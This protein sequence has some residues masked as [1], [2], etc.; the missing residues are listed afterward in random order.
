[1]FDIR[2]R[3][4]TPAG[5]KGRILSTLSI[6]STDAESATATLQFST[7][8][9][10]AGRLEAPF[11]VGLE[12]TTGGK[13]WSRPRND[14]YVVL[15][16]AENAKDQ[17][18][19]M[20]F[21]A[22]SYVGWLLSQ[23][24]HWW[25]T[26]STDGR[27]R[28]Y[29]M[30]PGKLVKQLVSEAQ[31]AG[32]GWAPMLTTAFSDTADSLG[33][34]WKADDQ[35]KME[36]D[37]WRPYSTLFQSW[38]E[39]GHF[40]WWAEGTTLML[41]RL[42]TGADLS[43]KIAL[44]GPGFESAP[45]KTD[46]KGTFSTIVLIP[47]KASATHAFNAGADTRFGALE[48]SMTMSGVSDHATAV[49]MAQPVMREN[50]A[51]KLEL[52]F[53]WTPAAG[54]PVPWVDFTIGDLVAARR[55]VGK[56]PQRVVGIQVS[57]RD[58]LVSARA[59]VGSKLVGLQAKIAKRAGSASQGGIIGGSGA[60]IPSNPGVKRP[61]PIAPSGLLVT[62][63]AYFDATG[64][65]YASV[66]ATCSTVTTD[67]LGGT[68]KV[69]WYELWARKNS[70]G[71]SWTRLSTT[72]A[73]P[74]SMTYTGLLA[75]ESW[76]FRVRAYVEDRI[77]SAFSPVFSLVLAKDAIAPPLPAAPSGVSQRAQVLITHS[78]LTAA[79]DEQPVD[80][81]HFNV[82]TATTLTGTGSKVGE[83]RGDTFVAP[84]QPYNQAR[85]FWVTAQD[86]SGN[87]SEPSERI[88]VTTL[89]LVDTDMIGRII[90]DAN[91]KLG[92]IKAEL[93]ENG[94]ILQDKLADNAVSL[95]KLDSAT[96]DTLTNASDNATTANGRVTT[97]T[98][99]PTVAN[100]AGKPLGALWF[101]YSGN[102]TLLGTWRWNGAAWDVQAWG[103]DAIAAGAIVNSKLAD[104]SI[105]AVKIADNAIEAGKIAANAVTAREILAG[106]ITA[107]SGI[108]ANASVG[109]AQIA[110]AA[111]TNAKIGTLDAGKITSGF[112][113]VARLQANSILA[114][115]IGIGD[116]TNYASGSDFENPDLNPWGVVAGINYISG[117]TAYTGAYSFVLKGNGNA[118]SYLNT[119]IPAKPGDTF[120]VEF[121]M[122]RSSLWDGLPANSKLRFGSG[123][124][125]AA[126]SYAA[127][128]AP[129]NVWTKRSLMFT[130][131]TQTSTA[132]MVQMSAML[133]N[134]DSTAGDCYLD[135]IVIRKVF[136]G[137]LL[138]D[139][140]ITAR[141][142]A[143]NA[144]TADK[145]LARAITTTKIAANAVTANEIAA[146]TITA[147]EIASNAITAAKI[148]ALA[149]QAGH[150]AA[151]AITA[152]K[153]DAGAITTIKLAALAITSEKIAAN[154][155]TASEL[156][157]NA[158]T[159]KHTITG[160]RFRTSAVA[161]RGIDINSLGLTMFN[162]AGQPTVMMDATNGD[163]IFTGTI[164]NKISGPRVSISSGDAAA[165]IYFYGGAEGASILPAQISSDPNGQSLFLY[166][167]NPNI[168]TPIFT[169]LRLNE[170]TSPISWLLG[171]SGFD[172]AT[173]YPR[174][175]GDESTASYWERST[176]HRITLDPNGW[177]YVVG[178]GLS[179]AGGLSVSGAKSFAME[180]PTKPGVTL[181]HAS[182]ESPHNGVEYWSDGL[183]EMP[184]QGFKTVTL[185]AY[186]EALTAPDHR[187]AILTA[188]SPDAELRYDPIVNGKLIV[189]GTPGALF[190][191]VVKARRVQ[192]VD[193]QDVLAFP[194]ESRTVAAVA[195]T[196]PEQE[197]SITT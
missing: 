77:V 108:L 145:V 6:A 82:W 180:H 73:E 165:T 126:L 46:F 190:S 76:S 27:T 111:I 32:R 140:A 64:T 114:N 144:I 74:P 12:Y 14:L 174:I 192:I 103:Q 57:K 156:T 163:A 133:V 193:G 71:E 81:S 26:D 127:A 132:G 13:S 4:F 150:I 121:W 175:R 75:G 37:L 42:G 188:G 67:V 135:D 184:A 151:N 56:L 62:S 19:V 138:V 45:A 146:L 29:N 80:F 95:A 125:L 78:G 23:A 149:I 41:A 1:M 194:T 189:H 173:A 98:A 16:D 118:N 105:N 70:S 22:Q 123:S 134:Q 31:N 24:I 53:D 72:E 40:E 179:I 36:V 182:T 143:T 153:I 172:G 59:I 47:D 3:E 168:S 183:V 120:Y 161:N 191:W 2:L 102:G 197:A 147:G 142:I 88:S 119:Q 20:T 8:S 79:G 124:W 52:S 155:I 115:K 176:G 196:E 65:A 166:G 39:Q 122:R 25:N 86:K 130:V 35:I 34:A 33:Q 110:D 169:V 49:R 5:V 128:D 101:R 186:F 43:S 152:D 139:G 113:D 107:A 69:K 60:G 50:R 131:P 9:R 91:I 21:T 162:S 160:A 148:A 83:L 170:R 96:R 99:A 90:A 51:K 38:I 129:A 167:G 68:I 54:G 11:V 17:T 93:I 92:A 89:P 15:S 28:V 44:G 187:V 177:T 159:S 171:R 63:E 136:G 154:A 85:W 97:S 158:I 66:T 109:T 84:Q 48:T 100:G 7:S 157:A 185:P 87:K 178:N 112:I 104:L 58:G 164:R 137:E 30:T 106:T 61:D 55:K 117:A 10:V 181:T 195:P 141:E 94:A 18:D 116:F